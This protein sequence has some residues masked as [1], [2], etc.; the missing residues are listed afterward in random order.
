MVLYILRDLRR[1]PNTPMPCRQTTARSLVREALLLA[2]C[3]ALPVAAWAA[4]PVPVYQV[5]VAGQS[6]PALEQAMR[7]ALVR[8]TGRRESAGDPAF[9]GLIAD[10]GKYVQSYDRGPQG[11][12]QVLFNGTAVDKVI[13][14]LDRSVWD[15]N[16][17]FTLVVLYP[18]PDQADQAGDQAAL[19]Q[20]AEQ[21]GLPISIV[22]LP[23]ADGSGNLLPREAL[24]EMAHRYGAEQLLVGSPPAPAPAPPAT[25]PGN[26]ASAG[27]AAPATPPGAAP[28]A[29]AA[30]G[31]QA[32]PTA[33]PAFAQ[34]G[35]AD[36]WQWHLY[37]DFTAQ[38]WSGQLTVGID[39]TVDLLA[40]PAGAVA[41]NGPG[42]TEVEIEGVSNLADYANIELMLGAVPGVSRAAVRQVSGD[43][44]LFDLTVRGGGAAIDR[45][46]S[47]SPSF[48]RLG[49]DTQGRG[50]S[51]A[52]LVYRYRPG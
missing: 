17:P 27:T 37:T 23:V 14:A 47:S 5:D 29:A 49:S 36:V 45:A 46:L 7:A 32:A 2:A 30:T 31:A 20:T 9:G 28:G 40:P 51:G 11:E 48:S 1:D 15:P 25:M 16:R 8:A 12:L 42:E 19:E 4:R 52:P 13:A 35:S 43:A 3:A 39:Y 50:V 26:G 18:S 33:A 24:L 10:A 6:G 22:P 41:A 21:R 44:V 38:S 34:P